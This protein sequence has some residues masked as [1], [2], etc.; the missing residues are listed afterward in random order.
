MDTMKIDSEDAGQWGVVY[1]YGSVL[2]MFENEQDAQNE[3]ASFGGA[4]VRIARNI[5]T[6]LCE[7]GVTAS[8]PGEPLP[9]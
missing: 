8:I 6:A 4:V 9:R 2:A 1:S 7:T 5:W 3:A